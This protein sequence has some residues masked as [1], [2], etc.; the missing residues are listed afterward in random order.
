MYNKLIVRNVQRSIRDYLIYIVTMTICVTLF[1][2]FLS[3]SSRYYKPDIGMEFDM[4]AL[5]DGMKLAICS[6]TLL[7]F[8]LIRYVNCYMLQRRQKEFAVQAVM[9]MEQKTIGWM[10]FAETLSMGLVSIVLGIFLGAVASQFISAMMLTSYGRPYTFTW[11]LFPD[12]VAL[13]ICFF[14]GSLFL[15]GLVSVR[16]IRKIK[17][18]DMLYAD[19]QNEPEIR[20]SRYMYVVAVLYWGILLAMTASGISKMHF[21]YDARLPWPVDLMY[22]GNILS[23]ALSLLAAAFWLFRRKTYPFRRYLAAA[24]ALALVNGGFAAS[25]PA[26]KDMYS[27]AGDQGILRLYLLYLLIDV[28]FI[29]CCVI[30]L[31]ST[32][33]ME[34]KEKYP[35]YKYKGSN[36]FFFGQVISKLNSNAKS[37]TLICL[38]LVVSVILFVAAPALTGWALGYLDVRALYDIQISTTYN[39]VEDEA[40]LPR[41]DYDV[42]TEF[43]EE[44]EISVD[45]DCTFNLYL[46]KQ[47]DFHNRYKLDFPVA[48]I[49]LSDYNTLRQ[50]Q[51]YEPVKLA[52]NEFTTQWQTLATEEEREEFL[53]AHPVVSTDSGEFTL[54]E[55]EY[56]TEPL[57]ETIYNSYTDVLYVFPDEAC[58]SFL[59]VMRNR[60][61]TTEET[62]SYETANTLEQAFLSQYPEE[63]DEE[64]GVQYLFRMSTLQINESKAS[65]F[66]MHVSMTYGAIVLM[67]ICL[68]ILS[69]QQLS[70]GQQCRYRFGVLHKLGVDQKEKDRLVLKQLSIWFGLPILVAILVSVLITICLFQ[71]ISLQITAYVGWYDLL[72]QV[73][74][75]VSILAMLLVCY[76]IS[77][78]ILFQRTVME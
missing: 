60:F 43:M 70:E 25:V 14:V 34:W 12:T 15:V 55:R 73:G 27:L 62:I 69:L 71:I 9:G 57:G 63:P 48:A 66:L 35:G 37:M 51:G 49:S 28:I 40:D 5:S 30:Y 52:E 58:Q 21:Y 61:I 1:Y 67:V 31:S 32:L 47:E 77:T 4:S 45:C 56:Y 68:T 64:T 59:P 78:W 16:S 3:I 46:T 2:A 29:I 18:I 76:F 50:M 8:F 44:H 24:A 65:T 26:V 42:V 74:I 75:M 10:Y 17:I 33:I 38:T 36:L 72:S 11:M 53:T 22:W 6:V 41:G 13:T 54:A 23:P 39:G 20:K 7:L 19:R